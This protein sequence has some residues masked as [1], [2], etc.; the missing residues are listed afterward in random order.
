[1]RRQIVFAA[2]VFTSLFA[3]FLNQ[4]VRLEYS[5][6]LWEYANYQLSSPQS[7]SHLLDEGE[8]LVFGGNI[9][10]PPLGMTEEETGQSIGFVIDYINAL[11]IQMGSSILIK[12]MVWSDALDA[13]EKGE[14]DLCDLIPS[15]ERE[16]RFLFSKPLY[17]LKGIAVTLAGNDSIAKLTDLKGKVIGAQKG[18]IAIEVLRRFVADFTVKEVDDVE[19]ALELLNE[20]KVD[21]VLGD[22]P[23]IWYYMKELSKVSRYKVIPQP[24]YDESCVIAV[25][26][27]REDLRDSINR[28]IFELR[29]NGTLD[30]INQK[31][32][33]YYPMLSKDVAGAKL[34]V[35]LLMLTSLL[36][37]LIS[38]A[39]Y[40]NLKLKTIIQHKTSELQFTFD[41]LNSFVA[42]LDA[43]GRITNINQAMIAYLGAEKDTLIGMHAVEIPIIKTIWD[44][45]IEDGEL[46][47]EGRYYEVKRDGR[48]MVFLR[49]ITLE[50]IKARQLIHTNRVEA[51]GQ[52]ASGVAHELRNPLGVIRNSTYL[53]KD[54]GQ[55]DD[56][57]VEKA[58]KSIDGA[59]ARSS[60]IIDK[61]LDFARKDNSQV[62]SVDVRSVIEDIIEFFDGAQK[63]K[64]MVFAL[65]C[66]PSVR[67]RTD[68]QSLHH[69]LINLI[70]NACDA[71]ET[72]GTIRIACALEQVWDGDVYE[73]I[74]GDFVNSSDMDRS[75]MRRLVI[76]VEDNGKGIS[77]DDVSRIFD[78]FFTTKSPGEGTGLGLYVVFTELTKIKGRIGVESEA[79]SW[80]RFTV[81]LEELTEA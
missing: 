18:D 51:I 13:L 27:G 3:V 16:K 21:A 33:G 6:N 75:L 10:E 61:L 41:S 23:V 73:G 63:G 29:R 81:T 48:H 70:G 56:P 77:N 36:G 14:T 66:D 52:L 55:T 20:G 38:F 59:I 58:L 50:K 15:A 54:V 45:G 80:S 78:P 35:I 17:N 67:F 37:A 34:K 62:T 32:S 72:A 22:E 76:V 1:M 71:I 28:A 53:L 5:I 7:V 57:I 25:P 9:S 11:S 43:E 44:E 69:I 46:H 60:R 12:P 26:K 65:T 40:A 68:E 49:D 19:Q 39:V 64:N 8:V 74:E 30:R 42:I 47:F 79:G 4:L 31:W 24:I 2:I